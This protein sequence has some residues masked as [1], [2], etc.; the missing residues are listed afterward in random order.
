MP[1]CE[2]FSKVKNAGMVVRGQ[3]HNGHPIMAGI[4]TA[5]GIGSTIAN[6]SWETDVIKCP[7]CG[8][9]KDVNKRK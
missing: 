4:I 1:K 8:A 7:D 6:F 3:R 2:K 9:T 5:I